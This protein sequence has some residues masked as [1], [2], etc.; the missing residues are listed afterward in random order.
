VITA[1]SVRAAFLTLALVGCGGTSPAGGT[2]GSMSIGT[3]GA[4]GGQTASAG[5]PGVAGASATGGGAAAAA[6]T[7]GSG[8]DSGIAGIGG[9]SGMGRT[10]GAGAFGTG[11]AAGTVVDGGTGGTAPTFDSA[12][13]TAI[14]RRVADYEIARFGTNNDN[15]WVRSVFHTGMLAAYR[16]LGAT[17]Y[18]DYTMQW[19]Q[20][21]NWKLHADS[22]GVRFADNQACAQSYAELYLAAPGPQND[23]M[24]AAAEAAFDMMVAAPKAGH[25]EWWWCDALY[26]APAAMVRVAQASG[27]TQYVTLMD[28]MFWDTK[29]VLYS[30][31]ANLFWRDASY[32]NKNTYWARGNGWVVA[33]IARILDMLP[34]AD[35]HTADYQ[36][37]LR[38]IAAKLI[39]LQGSDGFWRSSLTQPSAYPNPES[40]GTALF[41]FAMAWGINHGV[42][43]R[44]TFLPAVQKAWAALGTAVSAQGRLGWVQGVG[45]APGPATADST[46]DYATGAFLLAGSEVLKL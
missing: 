34:P 28:D 3:G 11:G 42:L 45:S 15:G 24:I 39:T 9:I 33:G 38:Q 40:S 20:A 44:A 26:M 21:N 6:G 18:H 41:C 5:A 36:A 19:G 14:M 2:G 37:L 12:A 4:T 22:D 30:T 43:D 31:S 17:K 32:V 7:R 8:G 16:A 10:G 29:A 13:V 1:R 23:D 35:T 25:V 27:K 46:N